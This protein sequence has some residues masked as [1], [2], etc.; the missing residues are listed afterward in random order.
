MKVS[1]K[2]KRKYFL[3]SSLALIAAAVILVV[4][5]VLATFMVEGEGDIDVHFGAFEAKANV[6]F[7]DGTETAPAVYSQAYGGYQV[8]VTEDESDEIEYIDNLKIQIQYRGHSDMYLRVSISEMWTTISMAN[9]HMFGQEIV[10]RKNP[11]AY[12]YLSGAWADVRKT[13]HLRFY[14]K[15]GSGADKYLIAGSDDPSFKGLPVFSAPSEGRERT[16][17]KMFVSIFIEC[18]QPT[19]FRQIWQISSMPA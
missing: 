6:Y 18:V 8:K 15:G 1:I 19:R 12:S 7:D 17:S 14:Y 11:L 16:G 4:A 9:D 5:Q 3:L 13:D 10:S 2:R